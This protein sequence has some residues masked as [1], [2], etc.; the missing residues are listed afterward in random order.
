[1]YCS[2]REVVS[3]IIASLTLCMLQRKWKIN[4]FQLQEFLMQAKITLK[5][6]TITF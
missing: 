1:M 6:N 4:E 3:C 5:I 2:L